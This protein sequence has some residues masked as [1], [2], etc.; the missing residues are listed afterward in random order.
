[1]SIFAQKKAATVD[2]IVATLPIVAPEP[3]PMPQIRPVSIERELS[4]LEEAEYLRLSAELGTIAGKRELAW[5]P[6]DE[7]L[8]ERGMGYYDYSE[9]MKFLT[10]QAPL[11]EPSASEITWAIT[12]GRKLP[13][14]QKQVSSWEPLRAK[15]AWKEYSSGAS[16]D[17]PLYAKKVPLQALQLVADIEKHAPDAYKFYVSDYQDPRPDPFLAVSHNATNERRVIFHW[18]EPMFTMKPQRP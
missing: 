9:V 1:M 8:H 5:R 12:M 6:L 13:E 3:L 7:F 14:K 4:E 15:D 10:E 18:D 16:W 17:Y 2:P 11:A